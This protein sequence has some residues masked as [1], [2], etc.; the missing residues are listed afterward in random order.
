MR[1]KVRPIDY[2]IPISIF[3]LMV[4]IFGY[5][6]SLLDWDGTYW[7][8]LPFII[9]GIIAVIGIPIIFFDELNK[10]E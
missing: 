5:I 3:L 9:S 1:N 4:W 7:W 6:G 10:M 8:Q 2:L